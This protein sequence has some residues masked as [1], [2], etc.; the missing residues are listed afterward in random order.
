MT[1]GTVGVLNVGAGDTT[2]TFDPNNPTELERAKRIVTDMLRRGYAILVQVGTKKGEPLYARAKGFDPATAEYLIVHADD[3]E[4]DPAITHGRGIKAGHKK[5]KG[6]GAGRERR[7][8]AASTRAVAVGRTA[9][10]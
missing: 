7:V 8:P 9:G 2:L 3:V 6:G 5:T 10:G 1:S 4:I